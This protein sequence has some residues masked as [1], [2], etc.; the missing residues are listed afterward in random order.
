[1]VKTVCTGKSCPRPR[2]SSARSRGK[3]MR[4][5][6]L[7]RRLRPGT[8]IRIY[9]TAKGKIGSYTSLLIRRS[10]HPSRRDLCL[11]LG[12]TRAIKCPS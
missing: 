11:G 9:V 6:R 7:E 3:A 2:A 8:R 5:R 4:L 12:T 1:M 10:K